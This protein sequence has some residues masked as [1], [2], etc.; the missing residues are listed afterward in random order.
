[1]AELLASYW[2]LPGISGRTTKTAYLDLFD[3]GI[4]ANVV[5]FV[6]RFKL[7]LPKWV[8]RDFL[9]LS[10]VIYP[11]ALINRRENPERVKIEDV[12][13]ERL[14]SAGFKYRPGHERTFLPDSRTDPNS[15]LEPVA[16][17]PARTTPNPMTNVDLAR[18]GE[19]LAMWKMIL[20]DRAAA[21][22]DGADLSK[23]S[24]VHKVEDDYGWSAF[25]V[26]MSGWLQ[27]A[28]R[29]RDMLRAQVKE[30]KAA[31]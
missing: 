6:D 16:G 15:A 29:E 27:A 26:I 17:D 24:G 19:P 28:Y 4:S 22:A 11:D 20:P 3:N 31:R 13:T 8:L 2:R 14:A 12:M 18:D 5:L 7:Q 1:M 21:E 10:A 25:E 23:W 30:L 9:S